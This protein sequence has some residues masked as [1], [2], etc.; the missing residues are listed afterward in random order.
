[1]VYFD[2][3]HAECFNWNP[4]KKHRKI[5]LTTSTLTL[6]WNQTLEKRLVERKWL[7]L[8]TKQALL[9]MS[10][11]NIQ[12]S[13]QTYSKRRKHW[14]DLTAVHI[15]TVDL[16]GHVRIIESNRN[17]TACIV[18]MLVGNKKLFSRSSVVSST[19]HTYAQSN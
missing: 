13:I 7:I 14:N 10:N 17:N 1:M 18:P 6:Y 4:S 5:V 12:L 11:V 3:T 8:M 9:T 2:D 16:V 15:Y 19:L